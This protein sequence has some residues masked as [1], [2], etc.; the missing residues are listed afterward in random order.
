MSINTTQESL[1]RLANTIDS[2]LGV[3]S[4]EDTGAELVRVL[5]SGEVAMRNLAEHPYEALM[6]RAFNLPTAPPAFGSEQLW[7][8]ARWACSTGERYSPLMTGAVATWMD[9]GMF[10]RETISRFSD[11]A[12]GELIGL[13][14]GPLMVEIINEM[15]EDQS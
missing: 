6:R 1:Q 9:A 11:F 3:V 2:D 8:E 10:A 14:G 15:E 4:N 5:N 13:L 7:E 12:Q